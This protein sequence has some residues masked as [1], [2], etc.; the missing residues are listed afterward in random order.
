MSVKKR[1]RRKGPGPLGPV[2]GNIRVGRPSQGIYMPGPVAEILKKPPHE[3]RPSRES[4]S[5]VAVAGT[6]DPL[7]PG[8][9]LRIKKRRI[10]IG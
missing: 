4:V 7:Q 1:D 6:P 5:T 9:T 2:Q 10:R 8:Y 3:I